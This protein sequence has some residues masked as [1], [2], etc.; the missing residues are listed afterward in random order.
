M[1]TDTSQYD[2]LVFFHERVQRIPQSRIS[3]TE[4][5]MSKDSWRCDLTREYTTFPLRPPVARADIPL[6]HE[7][8]T[9]SGESY[10]ASGVSRTLQDAKRAA[11]KDVLEQLPQPGT[12]CTSH[13]FQQ[14]LTYQVSRVRLR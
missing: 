10:K 12:P 14:P 2:P 13:V 1:A 9:V 7:V 5:M 3:W 4:A 8:E 11:A 6:L